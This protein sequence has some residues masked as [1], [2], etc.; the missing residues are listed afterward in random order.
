MPVDGE[1]V[2]GVA[3]R[4]AAHRL[5]LGQQPAPEAGL[6]ERFDDRDGVVPAPQQVDE[7]LPRLGGPRLGQGRRPRDQP[8][9]GGP[10]QPGPLLGGEDRHPQHQHRIGGRVG[11]RLEADLALAQDHDAGRTVAAAPAEQG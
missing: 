1:P 6:V 4:A 9:E 2:V 10:R 5:P 7:E 11:R 3:L 8:V